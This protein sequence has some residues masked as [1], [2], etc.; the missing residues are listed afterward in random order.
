MSHFQQCINIQDK[1]N[2]ETLDLNY[3]LDKMGLTTIYR[4]FY[5]SATECTFFSRVHGAFSM[6]DHMIVHK[7]SLKKFKNI[8]ILPSMF[9]D[10]NGMNLE[11]NKRKARKFTDM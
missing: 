3:T 9:S 5:P 4:T 7:T 2:Q 10:Y 8:E 11:I 6:I 1:I